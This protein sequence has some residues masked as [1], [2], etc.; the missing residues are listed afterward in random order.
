MAF[1]SPEF[2]QDHSLNSPLLVVVAV[3]AAVATRVLD[4]LLDP[5]LGAFVT[6]SVDAVSAAAIIGVSII[7]TG[8]VIS[9]TALLISRISRFTSGMDDL[10]Q[11]EA[12]IERG[13]AL[14]RALKDRALTRGLRAR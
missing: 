11:A 10:R 7:F 2:R 3:L 1:R 9:G 8:V 12:E 14:A 6:R 5:G 4:H 13:K